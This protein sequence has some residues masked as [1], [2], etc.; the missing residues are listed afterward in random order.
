VKNTGLPKLCYLFALNIWVA[1]KRLS[2]DLSELVKKHV[3][4][5]IKFCINCYS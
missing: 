2:T 1:T 3:K 5:N 4:S